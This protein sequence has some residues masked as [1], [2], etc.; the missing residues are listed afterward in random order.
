MGKLKALLVQVEEVFIDGTER[1]VQRPKNQDEQ[2]EQYSG[3][4]KRIK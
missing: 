2:Q 1:T 3:K 4:K